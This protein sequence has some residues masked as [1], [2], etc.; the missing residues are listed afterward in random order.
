MDTN[1][2]RVLKNDFEKNSQRQKGKSNI[3]DMTSGSPIRHILIFTLPLLIGNIFQQFYNLVDSI[4]VGQYVGED[5]LA[6]V[7][8]CGSMNFLFFSLSMGLASGIGVIISQNFGA[9]NDKGVRKAIGNSYYVLISVALVITILALTLSP[10]LLKLLKTPDEVMGEA[11][12]YMRITSLGILGITLYNGVA[13]ALRALGDSKTPLYFLIFS[14]CVNV[15]MD[16]TL[17][18]GFKMGVAGVAMAT[19]ISQYLSATIAFIYARKYVPYFRISKEELKPDYNIIRTAFKLGVPLALQSSLIAISCMVLQGI[20][21][22]FGKSVMTAYT[23]TGRVEQL[24][25]QPYGSIGI[26]VMTFAGQNMGANKID[27]VKKEFKE[28]TFV[29]LAFS[30]ILIPIMFL[31]GKPIA[32]IFVKDAEIIYIAATG[33]KMTSIFYFP[34]G[35]IY[36]PR[37]LCNGCGDSMFAMINGITE[38]FCRVFFSEFFVRMSLFGYWS[39][40]VTTACTWSVTA[41][42]CIGRYMQGK[43]K[44]GR[45]SS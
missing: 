33:L 26:A 24:V 21:N 45:L 44:K 11:I 34:L 28:S 25:Q 32:G 38:V 22:G 37:S 17:V 16:L 19:I 39:I 4:V 40:W 1:N 35:M 18:I 23:I 6:A 9:G 43:W 5:S 3:T 36:V 41:I 13:S 10:T 2:K 30:L 29:V 7:G 42:V 20:V 15:V 31:F 14:S 27:R 8:G 12:L